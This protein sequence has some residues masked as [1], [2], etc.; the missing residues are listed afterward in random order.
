[1]TGTMYQIG[2]ELEESSRVARAGWVGTF[3]LVMFPLLAPSVF[4]SIMY[5][6]ARNVAALETVLLLR[7]PGLEVLAT[8]LWNEWQ[9]GLYSVGAAINVVMFSLVSILWLSS[10]AIEKRLGSRVEKAL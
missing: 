6:T 9:Q 10:K 5:L 1:M 7:G 2:K 3:R 8:Q 4:G